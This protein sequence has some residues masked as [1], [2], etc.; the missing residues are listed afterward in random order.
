MQVYLGKATIAHPQ[1]ACSL[2]D[3]FQLPLLVAATI[4]S[5]GTD[6]CTLPHVAQSWVTCMQ[7]NKTRRALRQPASKLWYGHSKRLFASCAPTTSMQNFNGV[8]SPFLSW[9]QSSELSAV[10]THLPCQGSK[11]FSAHLAAKARLAVQLADDATVVVHLWVFRMWEL[12]I[13]QKNDP[14]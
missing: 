13:K 4:R 12:Q 1:S 9:K 14:F 11:V 8:V 2:A 3:N 5:V 7:R 6:G 10:L